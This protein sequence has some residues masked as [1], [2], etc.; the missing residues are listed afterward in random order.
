M[1]ELLKG[2]NCWKMPPDVE[3]NVGPTRIFPLPEGY[4][5]A[6]EKYG[7][8]TQMV[9]LP[10]GHYDLKNYIARKPFPAPSD[11]DK[12]WKNLAASLDGPVPRVPPRTPGKGLPNPCSIE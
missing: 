2:I 12:G 11:P 3:M 10:D 5:E 9:K 7:G 8:Q 1:V 4:P 6:T